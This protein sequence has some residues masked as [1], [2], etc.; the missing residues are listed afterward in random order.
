[1][2]LQDNT[3]SGLLGLIADLRTAEKEHETKLEEIRRNIDAVQLALSLLRERQGLPPPHADTALL[4]D[5][6]RGKSHLD[7]LAIIA[8][9]NNGIVTVTEAKRVFLQAGLKKNPKTAYQGITS[10]L[11][12]SDRF[13]YAEP[14]KYRLLRDGS[15]PLLSRAG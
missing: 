1:M 15:Q 6:V 9:A 10:V 8:E 2:V 7:A 14:G 3:Q 4:V 13:E 5:R 12:R 11:I